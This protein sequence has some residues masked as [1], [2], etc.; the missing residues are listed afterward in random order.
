MTRD[1]LR[2]LAERIQAF[3]F[4][5]VFTLSADGTI[6]EPANVWAPDVYHDETND[7]EINGRGDWHAMTGLTGQY[8]YNGAVMHASEFIGSGVASAMLDLCE[9]GPVTFAVVVVTDMD[10]DTDAGE[11]DVVGWAITYKR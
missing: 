4:D 3:D 11:D 5:H 10:A 2:T 6:T 8:S 9:D 7:V 1:E